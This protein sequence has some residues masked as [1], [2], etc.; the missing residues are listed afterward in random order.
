MRHILT[1]QPELQADHELR[2][3]IM[4][5]CQ[6]RGSTASLERIVTNLVG[7]AAKYSPKGST[8][9]VRVRPEGRDHAV[10]LV[11]DQGSGV[12][13][14]DRD[15]VFSRFYRGRGDSVTRTR[16]AGIG[17]AIVS[18]YAASMSGTARVTDAPGGGA[19]FVITFPMITTYAHPSTQ[20]AADVTVS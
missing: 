19:R 20:G 6:V 9:T 17:L 14:D 8:V 13:S 11:D 3:D 7:N 12:P 15:K 1:D 18:E 16:G 2:L 4:S 5:G 10:L